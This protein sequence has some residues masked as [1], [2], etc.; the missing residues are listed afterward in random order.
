LVASKARA[1]FP[2]A[3]SPVEERFA[4]VSGHRL[5]YLRYGSGPPLVLVHGLLGYSYC[6][7]SNIE[8]L[9]RVATVFAPDLLGCGFSDRPRDLDCSLVASGNRLLEFMDVVGVERADVA[10]NSHGGPIAWEAAALARAAGRERVRSLILVAPVNPFSERT[11]RKAVLF[12]STGIGAL[13]AR[14]GMPLHLAHVIGLRRLYGDP[15]TIAPGTIRAYKTALQ[16]PGTIPYLRN[17]L[18]CWGADLRELE[19]SLG[20]VADLPALLLWGTRDAAVRLSSASELKAVLHRAE[21]A[22]F[23]GA[24]HLLAEERPDE[25]NRAVTNFLAQVAAQERMAGKKEPAGKE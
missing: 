4:R 12:F 16:L 1:A 3:G 11:P 19:R 7:R 17:V 13:A 18:Q 25:F 9:G 21:L 5:R 14:M 15:S 2:P 22:V 10:G 6:W 8:A 24:G 23:E 20:Q